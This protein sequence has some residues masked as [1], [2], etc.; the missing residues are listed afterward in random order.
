VQGRIPGR[1]TADAVTTLNVEPGGNSP[2][3][4]RSKPPGRS[5]T[6]STF[7]DGQRRAAGQPGL[8]D[9][10]DSALADLIA[11]LVGSAERLGL[12]GGG[13][14]HAAGEQLKRPRLQADLLHGRVFAPLPAAQV[15][16]SGLLR[17][18]DRAQQQATGC[19][20]AR[21][22]DHYDHGYHHGDGPPP[23]PEN[24]ALVQL[25]QG[26]E[27]VAGARVFYA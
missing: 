12:R 4:A 23:A 1:A 16:G 14:R 22:H 7:P 19:R 6:A 10:L 25:D 5:T 18:A 9:L 24:A 27:D 15:A 20:A 3:N 26:G 2:S 13:R 21:G 8:V 17:A 11:G